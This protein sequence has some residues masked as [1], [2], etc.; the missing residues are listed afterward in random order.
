MVAMFNGCNALS[1]LNLSSFTTEQITDMS[2]LFNGCRELGELH[3][4]NF[5]MTHVTNKTDMCLNLAPN[6]TV[7]RPAEIW[8]PSDVQTAISDPTTG[9]G[10]VSRFVFHTTTR[11][12]N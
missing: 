12:N 7:W 1:V 5:D 4:N 11:G 9:I 3:I 10:D 2:D 6:R 8:C